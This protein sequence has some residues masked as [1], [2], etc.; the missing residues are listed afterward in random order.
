MPPLEALEGLT[1]RLV[2]LALLHSVWLGLAAA[3]LASLA[4]RTGSHRRRHALGLAALLGIPLTLPI[5]IA[6]PS[7]GAAARGPALATPDAT[8]QLA[9]GQGPGTA[10]ATTAPARRPV[11]MTLW[12]RRP[13]AVVTAWLEAT[14]RALRAAQPAGLTVWLVAV[15]GLAGLFALGGW[16]LRR[17]VGAAEPAPGWVVERAADLARRLGLRRPPEVRVQSRWPVPCLCGG[18]R[19][20]VLLPRGWLELATPALLD[21]VLA[22]ELAHARRRDPLANWVQRLV[23]IALW[24]HPAVHALSR[25]LRRDREFAADA[26]ACH[27]T[28]D[29]LSLALALESIARLRQARSLRLAPGTALGGSDAPSLLPRIQELL[30]MTPTRPTRPRWPLAAL[31]A[32]ALLALVAASAGRADD[33]A[34]AWPERIQQPAASPVAPRT[35]YDPRLIAYEVRLAAVAPESWQLSLFNAPDAIV[36]GPLIGWTVDEATVAGLLRSANEQPGGW[37]TQAPKVTGDL[38]K[39]IEIS[40]QNDFDGFGWPW[41][42][43]LQGDDRQ[44]LDGWRVEVTGTLDEEAVQLRV[45]LSDIPTRHGREPGQVVAIWNDPG[46]AIARIP[47][48][49]SLVLVGARYE[50]SGL[51]EAPAPCDQVVTITPRRIIS[52][53]EKEVLGRAVPPAPNPEFPR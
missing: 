20:L 13:A 9:V 2:W 7:P 43:R 17:I 10:P 16:R 50:M 33:P 15:A 4:R 32:A 29:P 11:G 18:W 26:M 14:S 49:S 22:H 41:I 38:A 42:V 21:A 45:T 23:E 52:E 31:P 51:L 1:A 27:L 6:L 25:S 3:A 36:E 44:I 46:R 48:G 12:P 47:E 35:A 30:G 19:P 53:A 24:F 40:V 34:P 37:I 39:P 28:S 5:A 8:I